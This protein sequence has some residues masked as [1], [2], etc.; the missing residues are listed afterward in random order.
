MGIL[1]RFFLFLFALVS[2]V[3]GG[4][5]LIPAARLVPEAAWLSFVHP[6]IG[7]PETLFGLGIYLLV[8]LS[9]L[10]SAVSFPKAG[11]ARRSS[12]AL[13]AGDAGA[14]DVATAAVEAVACRAARAEKGVREADARLTAKPQNGGERLTL[15][16]RLAVG[17]DTSVPDVTAAVAA[18]V[19]GE[20]ARLL[21][22]GDV[23][24]KITIS[25]ITQGRLPHQ[26][27]VS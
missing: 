27:R 24:L 26:P 8:A 13:P 11:A 16:L 12:V 23:A 4:A 22:L 20:L 17:T 1:T 9:L 14:V 18:A 25:D 6:Y 19:Q 7:R 2:L 3:A 15:A 10:V 5:L 21:G